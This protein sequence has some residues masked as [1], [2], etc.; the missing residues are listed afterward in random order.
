MFGI[1]ILNGDHPDIALE[2][3]TLYGGLHSGD[4]FQYYK[5]RWINAHLEYEDGDIDL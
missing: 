2:N 3:G 1:L 5:D 4:C